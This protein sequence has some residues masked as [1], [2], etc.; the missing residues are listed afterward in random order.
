MTFPARFV[1]L[2]NGLST[3]DGPTLSALAADLVNAVDGGAGG[4]YNPAAPII[5][6]GSGIDPRIADGSNIPF[7]TA[8]TRT[9]MASLANP[10]KSTNFSPNSQGS[11]QSSALGGSFSVILSTVHDGATLTGVTL[12]FKISTG[13]GALPANF[14]KVS[15]ARFDATAAGAAVALNNTDP[16]TG[17]AISAAGTVIAYEN[18]GA[19]QSFN[20]VC[21]QNNVID[22]SKHVLF[23][24][25]TDES[26]ANAQGGNLYSGA[27]LAYGAIADMRFP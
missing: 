2:V 1:G 6:G 20:Y 24:V 26:G 22:H 7:K 3:I 11:Q 16:G 13:H 4:T 10:Y 17:L 19:V 15:V 8:R 5:I 18:G 25:L 9:A 23:L 14:P 21:N 12:Y 27:A